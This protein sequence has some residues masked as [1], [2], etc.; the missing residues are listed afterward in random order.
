MTSLPEDGERRPMSMRQDSDES[1][2][3]GGLSDRP[4]AL[5]AAEQDFRERHHLAICYVPAVDVT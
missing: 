4:P 2:A 1:P 5:P 3:G